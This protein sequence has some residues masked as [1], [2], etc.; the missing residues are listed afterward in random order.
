M[1]GPI[2]EAEFNKLPFAAQFPRD[3]RVIWQ[4]CFYK[5]AEWH[6][7]V[8]VEKLTRIAGGEVVE[9]TYMSDCAADPRRDYEVALATFVTQHVSFPRVC[10][11]MQGICSDIHNSAAVMEKY[12]LIESQARQDDRGASLM[13][14][15]ELEYAIVLVRSLYDLLQKL[16]K[17]LAELTVKPSDLTARAFADLPDSF[18]R[19]VIEGNRPR[20]AGRIHERF[21]LPSRLA[22]FYE[23]HATVFLAIRQIR[24]DIAHHGTQTPFALRFEEG[25]AISIEDEHWRQLPFWTSTN[26]LRK[27]FGSVRSVIAWLLLQPLRASRE[28]G[29]AFGLNIQLPNAMFDSN[30]KVYLRNELSQHLGRLDTVVLHPWADESSSHS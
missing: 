15:T 28:F 10:G 6:F 21:A 3:G 2:T 29:E 11:I 9:G 27:R 4:P 12:R 17:T 24:D 22:S 13:A 18:A 26:T 19:V 1:R 23:S 30:V 25:L 8:S 14:R 16:S 20:S 5:D 7:Y